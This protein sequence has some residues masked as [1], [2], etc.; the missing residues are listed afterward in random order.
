MNSFTVVLASIVLSLVVA[1]EVA[2]QPATPYH[3]L[4]KTVSIDQFMATEA[5]GGSVTAVGMTALL[6]AAMVKDGR[7]VVVERTGL[8]SISAEQVPGQGAGVVSETLANT[9]QLISAGF[10]VRGVVTKYEP[11]ASGGG[12]ALGGFPLGTF[13]SPFASRAGL[14][15]QTAVMEISIRLIDTSTSQ[16]I[17]TSTAQGSASSTAANAGIVDSVTGA[18]LGGDVFRITPIGQAGEQ[19]IVKAVEQIADGM[20]SVPWS[21]LVVDAG[22]GKVYVNAG[23]ERNIQAGMILNAYRKGR[24]FTDPATGVV[25]DVDMQKIG[26]IRIE[27]V[28]EKLS[29]AAVI[30][31]ESPLRGDLLKPD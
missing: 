7:F 13:L 24:V 30:S 28:R 21:A 12:V 31:G 19:A 9:R 10:I 25:L 3:G 5:V 8:A 2:S 17:S 4:K 1:K 22:D 23:A 11:A 15:R 6:T 26:V 29:T 16:V 27:S 14:T 20:K 18:S